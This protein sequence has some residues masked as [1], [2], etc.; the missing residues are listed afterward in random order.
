MVLACQDLLQ[1]LTLL[2]L[3]MLH[4]PHVLLLLL[5]LQI[6]QALQMQTAGRLLAMLQVLL[7]YWCWGLHL[8]PFHK[9]MA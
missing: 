5:L 7:R 3:L 1:A 4:L 9:V 2:L 6:G 8:L